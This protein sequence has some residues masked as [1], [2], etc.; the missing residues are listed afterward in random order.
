MGGTIKIRFPNELWWD[1]VSYKSALKWV[2][3]EINYLTDTTCF[4]VIVDHVG[5]RTTVEL[6]RKDYDKIMNQKAFRL[7]FKLKK[8]EIL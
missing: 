5:N 6:N 8:H 4:V 7:K 2:D 1:E 3:L